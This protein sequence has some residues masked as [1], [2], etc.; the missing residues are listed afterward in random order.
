MRL[1]KIVAL[2]AGVAVLAIVMLGVTSAT[3]TALC[4]EKKDECLFKTGSAYPAGTAIEATSK[5]SLFKGTLQGECET[6]TAKVTTS[7]EVGKPLGGEIGQLTFSGCEPC[8][9]VVV[10]K[11]PH[12]VELLAS[13]GGKA[14]LVTAAQV[15]FSK[16]PLGISCVFGSKAVTLD[17]SSEP[18]LLVAKEEELARKV[19]SELLCGEAEKWSGEYEITAPKPFWLAK[20]A[21]GTA[22]CKEALDEC[23]L[24]ASSV[25]PSGTTVE[26][27]STNAKFLGG[28]FTEE[29]KAS[30]TKFLT[31]ATSGKPLTGKITERSFSGCSPCT[32][33]AAEGL[34][35]T[36]TLEASSAGKGTLT[37]SF[38]WK[39]T[40]CPLGATCVFGSEGL[41]AAVR[42]EPPELSYNQTLTL[43]EGSAF[44]C[45][46]EGEWHGSE[47]IT[48]PEPLWVSNSP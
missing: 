45:G 19:G 17:A 9:S 26:A 29:C 6:S 40:S 31:T 11:L 39:L 16:C 32:S 27:T 21:S 1:I 44:L 36:A 23:P 3:G 13:G 34:P 18:A 35:S 12:S 25:Y 30:T 14:T 24:F 47:K 2:Y 5:N 15:A 8:E 41:S 4:K 38:R 48:S 42:S 22:I 28:L 20:T 46:S 33:A 37:T 43:K 7:A 10:E